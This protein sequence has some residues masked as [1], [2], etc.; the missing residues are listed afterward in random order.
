MAQHSTQ[1]N[2]AQH[3]TAHKPT[4]RDSA[5]SAQRWAFLAIYHHGQ[6][7]SS[8]PRPLPLYLSVKITT[9]TARGASL[10]RPPHPRHAAPEGESH[11][12]PQHMTLFWST[13]RR[14]VI[15]SSRL[16][17]FQHPPTGFT[18][19]EYGMLG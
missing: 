11:R 12:T 1:H 16:P 8:L 13:S 19:H 14:E 7:V 10:P 17:V 18:V 15:Q 5:I 4:W 6:K 2:T 3:S 9:S